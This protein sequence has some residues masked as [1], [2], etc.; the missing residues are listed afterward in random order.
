MLHSASGFLSCIPARWRRREG[1]RRW[2]WGSRGGGGAAVLCPATG[3]G[4]GSD[5]TE[6]RCARAR[7]SAA[8]TR[9]VDDHRLHLLRPRGVGHA[10]RLRVGGGCGCHLA[11]GGPDLHV[12]HVLDARY[13]LQ[14][15]N[16]PA[17]GPGR[18]AG[19]AGRQVACAWHTAAGR[20]G[21]VQEAPTCF[22]APVMRMMPCLNAEL[23]CASYTSTALFAASVTRSSLQSHA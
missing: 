16:Q 23:D 4:S 15:R 19:K 22:V 11:S 21:S 8:L 1:G 20:A 18:Q 14:G 5:R 12:D 13:H 17:S 10:R 7:A 9:L 3:E 6:R 2:W